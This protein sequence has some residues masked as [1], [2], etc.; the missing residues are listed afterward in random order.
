MKDAE[1]EAESLS[2]DEKKLETYIKKE[3]DKLDYYLGDTE[4]LI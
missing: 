2:E 1:A 4:E 3:I